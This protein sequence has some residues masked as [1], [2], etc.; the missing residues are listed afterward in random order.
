MA[1]IEPLPILSLR[2]SRFRPCHFGAPTA[3]RKASQKSPQFFQSVPESTISFIEVICFIVLESTTTLWPD[4]VRY[5]RPSTL[6]SIRVTAPMAT[7]PVRSIRRPA[8]GRHHK[9]P[10][11]DRA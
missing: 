6:G 4:T 3:A 9:E 7:T 8:R 10:R 11:L 5:I 2:A 1:L